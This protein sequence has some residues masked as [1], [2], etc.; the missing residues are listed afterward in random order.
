MKTQLVWMLLA[1]VAVPVSAGDP[2]AGSESPMHLE[3]EVPDQPPGRPAHED[4]FARTP[5]M[6]VAFGSYES[7]QVNVDAAG[8]N[9]VGDAANEPS[10]AANPLNPSNKVVGWRQFDTVL[11]NFRQ[12]GWAYTFDA[13][14]SWTFPGVLTP[15]VF[16]SDPVIEAD[17]NGTFFYQSLKGNLALDVFRSGD[18][19]VTWSAPVPSFGGDKNWLAVSR[20]GGMSN[21]F[22]YGI[23]QRFGGACCGLNVFTRSIDGG[24]SWQTP[25]PV[26]LWPTFGTLT[27][28]PSGE[29]YAAGINGTTGQDITSYVVAKSTD[30]GNAAVTPTFTGTG[31]NLG[32]SM[33]VGGSEPN[34]EGLHGQP[35]V[36][37]NRA[38][39]RVGEVYVLGSVDD[40][41]ADPMDVNLIRSTDGGASWSPPV[42]INDDA[43]QAWQWMAAAAVAPNGRIDAIWYDTRG[44]GLTNVAQLF[45]A[46]S[47]DGGATWSPNTAVTPSFNT[48]V[49]YPQQGKMGDYIGLL[50]NDT[51]ADAAYTATF[52]NEQDVYYVRLF[53]DC[54]GNGISDVTDL[55]GG[56]ATDCNA[57]QVP[58]TCEIASC[59][60]A[61]EVPGSGTT[62]LTILKG[63]AGQI[64]LRWGTSCQSTDPDYAVYEGSIGGNFTSHVQRFCTTAGS[65]LKLLTPAA[66]SSYYLVVPTRAGREGSYGQGSSGV[67]RAPAAAACMPQAIHACGAP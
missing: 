44:S 43:G 13:G 39:G 67:E 37:V 11:S 7:I 42:Q 53:P 32:G 19:G 20:T 30:A 28:G 57:N 38:P 64:L 52:N 49:G 47:W 8:N 22:L 65:K 59:T 48:S 35:N 45:Y 5:G 54:N 26:A 16:R 18:G 6:R 17:G 40:P 66:G 41:T 14:A 29:V 3:R 56:Q 36:F 60:G 4:R 51:G 31:V 46:Y 58:D 50:A 21:N 23:W 55:A 33:K 27:V 9:I 63:S 24:L 1:G 25:V 12:A 62:P 10:I 34:P 61:G 2:D 15:G